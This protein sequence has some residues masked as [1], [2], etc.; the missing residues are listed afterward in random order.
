MRLVVISDTHTFEDEVTIPDGDVLIHAGDATISGTVDEVL[1]FAEWLRSQPHRHKIF[2]AG[3]HDWLFQRQ[4]ELAR[5]LLHNVAHYLEDSELVIEG[6]RFY[7]SPWQ[8]TFG[9]WAFNVNRGRAITRKWDL[10]QPCDV[11]ITHGPP[12]GV[13]DT[14]LPNSRHLGCEELGEAVGR[15]RPRLHVF[16]HIH[17]GY[18][19]YVAAGT[20]F[21]NASICDEAYR[22]INAPVVVELSAHSRANAA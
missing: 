11:L 14:V 19:E 13:L 21:V 6:V 1:L 17:G 20:R 12:W 5:S 18:G 2:V 22:P 7:G 4:P 15:V 10:I 9:N 16:G 8:P 3:N